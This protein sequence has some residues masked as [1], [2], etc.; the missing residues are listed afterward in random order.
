LKG[1]P[2]NYF[3]SL[4]RRTKPKKRKTTSEN[5][6]NPKNYWK[7]KKNQKNIGKAKKSFGKSKN[8]KKTDFMERGGSRQA[9]P[10]FPACCTVP[11][12]GLP[13]SQGPFFS[14]QGVSPKAS[15]PCKTILYHFQGNLDKGMPHC[16]Q[17]IQWSLKVQLLLKEYLFKIMLDFLQGILFLFK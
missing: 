9:V 14:K 8:K 11:P 16:S 5:K 12:F 2:T 13:D 7:N 6:R 10:V 3:H 17:G 4:W 15:F 1:G